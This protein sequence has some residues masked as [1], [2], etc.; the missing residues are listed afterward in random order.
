MASTTDELILY[1]DQNINRAL[2]P[3]AEAE[4]DFSDNPEVIQTRIKHTRASMGET[5]NLIQERLQEKFSPERLTEQAQNKIR[6]MTIG[7]VE[8]MADAAT[9]SAKN[10]RSS[11]VRTVRENPIPSALVGIGLGWLLFQGNDDDMR[12]NGG[13]EYRYVSQGYDYQ[14]AYNYTPPQEESRFFGKAQ[15]N[16]A[17]TVDNVKNTVTE[18]LTH[19]KER[20]GDFTEQTKEQAGELTQQAQQQA[21][22]LKD[23]TKYQMRRTKQGFWQMMEENPLAVGAVVLAAG[24]VIGLTLPK[25]QAEDEWL[26]DKRDRLVDQVQ[27]TAKEAVEKVKNIASEVQEK[28]VETAKEEINTQEFSRNP[29]GQLNS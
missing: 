21:R 19:A 15:S 5:I 20:V 9:R 28:A 26:G 11:L 2:N 29:R 24:A 16:I 6:E 1:D 8:D 22:M 3:I 4:P 23:Q 27:S 14:R 25:T 7:K 18:S 17:D 12:E 10:W 13:D